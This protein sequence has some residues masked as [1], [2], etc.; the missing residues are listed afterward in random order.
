MELYSKPG[1]TLDEVGKVLRRHPEVVEAWSVTGEADAL[2]AC[3][4][5]TTANSSA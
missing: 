1:T 2:P 3:E 5:K 4:P